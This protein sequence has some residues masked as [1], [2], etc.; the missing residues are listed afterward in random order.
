MKALN[1]NYC[2]CSQSGKE[3][4]VFTQTP[5]SFSIDLHCAYFSSIFVDAVI[6]KRRHPLSIKF[7]TLF[8]FYSVINANVSLCR[9]LTLFH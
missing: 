2:M 9:G 8:G 4:F 1:P 6:G 7:Q 3:E 5:Q